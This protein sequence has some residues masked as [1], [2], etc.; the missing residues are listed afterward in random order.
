MSKLYT[1]DVAYEGNTRVT[2]YQDNK[3]VNY[4]I[5]SDYN[6]SYHLEKL[7]AKGYCYGILK[8]ETEKRISELEAELTLLKNEL[9]D[10]ESNG[11]LIK[12]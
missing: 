7:K 2:E 6:V 8:S 5:V 3:V 11:T 4:E 1:F 12:C 10:A 9:K